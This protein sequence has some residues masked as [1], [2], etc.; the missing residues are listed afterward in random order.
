ML[1][2]LLLVCAFTRAEELPVIRDVHYPDLNP[3]ATQ[4]AFEY[5]GDIWVAN[6]EDGI[7]RR[8]TVSDAYESRPRFSPD[9]KSIAFVSDRY[10]NPDVFIMPAA[11]GTIQRVTYHTASDVLADWSPDG[12]KL[13]RCS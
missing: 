2:P 5:Q 9:G 3:D 8:L 6:V 1:F 10:G 11:G 4:I 13:L 12:K 7:G